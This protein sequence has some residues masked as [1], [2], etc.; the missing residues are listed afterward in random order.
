MNKITLGLLLGAVR[1]SGLPP[2]DPNKSFYISMAPST[3]EGNAMLVPF[4]LTPDQRV[5]LLP[6][7]RMETIGVNGHDCKFETSKPNMCSTPNFYDPLVS[8]ERTLVKADDDSQ[9][10]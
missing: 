6:T 2:N 7:T 5:N 8:T 4:D 10:F 9:V 3:E 1:S